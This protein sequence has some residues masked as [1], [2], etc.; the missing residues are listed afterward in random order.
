LFVVNGNSDE[1][2]KVLDNNTV[3][4]RTIYFSV[5]TMTTLGFGDISANPESSI[6]HLL[7]SIQVIIG[8]LFFGL[9]ITRIAVLF[10]TGG[11]GWHKKDF[12]SAKSKAEELRRK[13][14]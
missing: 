1:T 9:L 4:A 13:H 7:L 3:I 12:L 6:G 2:S 14:L 8:Y 5:V 11:P 10:T